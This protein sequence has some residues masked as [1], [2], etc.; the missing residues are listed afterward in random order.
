VGPGGAVEGSDES[1][2]N[3]RESLIHTINSNKRMENKKEFKKLK[4]EME[5]STR[6]QFF[7]T[8]IQVLQ[9][10]TS[11]V[12]LFVTL[13]SLERAT[14]ALTFWMITLMI[15]IVVLVVETSFSIFSSSG[16]NIEYSWY[17]RISALEDLRELAD[18]RGSNPELRMM[19]LRHYFTGL[20]K[21]HQFALLEG[22]NELAEHYKSEIERLEK[23]LSNARSAQ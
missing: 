9:F 16:K 13:I 6:I 11:L 19:I 2:G 12:A 8:K 21:F 10:I 7:A 3:A 18:A 4:E 23:I 15:L 5:K 14:N 17:S 20:R 22:R 1:L